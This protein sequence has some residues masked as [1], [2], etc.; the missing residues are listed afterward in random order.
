[1]RIVVDLTDAEINGLETLLASLDF[2]EFGFDED[3]MEALD[4]AVD[5]IEEAISQASVLVDDNAGNR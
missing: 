2:E 1:M 5:K 3:E 4:S